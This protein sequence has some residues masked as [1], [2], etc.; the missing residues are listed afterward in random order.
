MPVEGESKLSLWGSCSSIQLWI[1]I[2]GASKIGRKG[3]RQH[4]YAQS[5]DK[6]EEDVQRGERAA[7]IGA[8]GNQCA[9][10]STQSRSRQLFD[11]VDPR[12]LIV[13]H[14]VEF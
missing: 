2:K 8:I 5:R 6:E 11:M 12:S 13:P 4:D 10:V 3:V 14:A 9:G 7:K 1:S